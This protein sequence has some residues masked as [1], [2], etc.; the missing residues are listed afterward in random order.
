[1]VQIKNI[2]TDIAKYEYFSVIKGV[3]NLKLVILTV[4][5]PIKKEV[6][7]NYEIPYLVQYFD[8]IEIIP[9]GICKN[10]AVNEV[11]LDRKV[12]VRW[13][14]S[15]K[16]HRKFVLNLQPLLNLLQEFIQELFYCKTPMSIV[17]LVYRLTKSLSIYF[18]LKEGYNPED[19]IIFYSYWLNSSAIALSLLHH[20]P[21]WYRIARAHG[22]DVFHE[23]AKGGYNPFLKFMI[24]NLDMVFPVSNVGKEYLIKHYGHTEK[25]IVQRLG[26][27]SHEHISR[28]S[29]DGVFRIVSCS[30]LKP[31]KRVDRIVRALRFFNVPVEWVHFGDGPLRR[32]IEKLA[33][34]LLKT[35]QNVK[36]QFMGNVDNSYIHSYYRNNPVDVFV[37]VSLSEGVPV[38]IME[39][40]SYG[41]PVVA[42]PVGGI[43][44]IVTQQTGRLIDDPDN[45]WLLKEFLEEVGKQFSS[46]ES[47]KKVKEFWQNNYNASSN[48]ESFARKLIELF[49]GEK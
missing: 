34:K 32:K 35:R 29:N 4:S 1:V 36:W 44:E 11:Y 3:K 16:I 47:R 17:K 21:K 27:L 43:P 41:I 45:P 30:S 5:Y 39:A 46:I 31:L 14:L 23:H 19:R 24:Q 12:T 10:N 33:F 7:L 8:R 26:S 6:F 15:K 37:N 49:G 9:T 20:Y 22:S 2:R 25:I 18:A 13:D 38:S 28:H 48:Y 42:P 40:I